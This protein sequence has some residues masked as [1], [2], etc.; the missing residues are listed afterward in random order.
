[1]KRRRVEQPV[2]RFAIPACHFHERIDER[3]VHPFEFRLVPLDVG[4]PDGSV[5]IKY[6]ERG[7]LRGPVE[8]KG[9]VRSVLEGDGDRL[10]GGRQFDALPIGA[11]DLASGVGE[12]DAVVEWLLYPAEK[13]S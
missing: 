12:V 6:P 4:C 5:D 8:A 13:R 1:M 9:R 2:Q 10:T 7:V 3:V 11:T